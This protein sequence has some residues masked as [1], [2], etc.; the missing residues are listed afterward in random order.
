VG[1]A[2]PPLV[3]FGEPSSRLTNLGRFAALL[4]TSPAIGDPRALW[5]HRGTDAK[6]EGPSH[7]SDGPSRFTSGALCT[8]LSGRRGS[9]SRSPRALRP[10]EHAG[11]PVCAQ[12]RVKGSPIAPHA[13]PFIRLAQPARDRRVQVVRSGALT[14]ASSSAISARARRCGPGW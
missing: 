1:M 14:R 6:R 11:A 9:S 2:D 12:R 10:Q 7:G 3:R 4:E 8:A 5:G 13:D